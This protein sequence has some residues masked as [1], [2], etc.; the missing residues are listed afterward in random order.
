MSLETNDGVVMTHSLRF[1][2][3]IQFIKLADLPQLYAQIYV[4][5]IAI[6]NQK[7]ISFPHLDEDIKKISQISNN[8]K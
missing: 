7:G 6:R 4:N 2:P 5:G 1:I 3:K 8:A